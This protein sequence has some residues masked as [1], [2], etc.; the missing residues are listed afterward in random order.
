MFEFLR[1][2]QGPPGRTGSPGPRGPKGER[3]RRGEPG[4]RGQDGKDGDD[5]KNAELCD[6]ACVAR[7]TNGLLGEAEF[8]KTF[9][10]RVAE[11]GKIDRLCVGKT[12][13]N[14]DELGRMAEAVDD[15]TKRG[16]DLES[17]INSIVTRIDGI[18][19]TLQ[20]HGL[21]IAEQKDAANAYD[22]KVQKQFEMVQNKVGNLENRSA[23]FLKKGDP[24]G[25]FQ[26]IAKQHQ[27]GFPVF[28]VIGNQYRPNNQ[29]YKCIDR[30]ERR[31]CPE[32]YTCAVRGNAG[33]CYELNWNRQH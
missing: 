16:D 12:C 18:D 3:G 1:G 21:A 17:R 15:S 25:V 29:D 6:S 11:S 9:T 20:E 26:T 24:A 4:T 7:V 10:V 33:R 14:G 23:T 19:K 13:F 31:A 27:G 30:G 32:G 28:P 5:G 22:S 8:W 2:P